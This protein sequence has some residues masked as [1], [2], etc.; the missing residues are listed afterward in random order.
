MFTRE[1]GPCIMSSPSKSTAKSRS[2]L[3]AKWVLCLGPT[4]TLNQPV[5]SVKRGQGPRPSNQ[6]KSHPRIFL[7]VRST[8]VSLTAS[9]SIP[10]H[11]TANQ[12][13]PTA[14]S[15]STQRPPLLRSHQRTK[16]QLTHQTLTSIHPNA[17]GAAPLLCGT[18][19]LTIRRPG[20]P[21]HSQQLDYLSRCSVPRTTWCLARA[22]T[23]SQ[24]EPERD[25]RE[26]ESKARAS[27][28]QLTRSSAASWPVIATSSDQPGACVRAIDD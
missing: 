19:R 28:R 14:L 22:Q 11:T 24:S 26:I 17:S 2:Q 9:H 18:T 3:V 13:H 10:S 5:K 16:D 8:A 6:I 15:S 25:K 12:S 27:L 21:S 7:H 23:S 20:C 1:T 4:D